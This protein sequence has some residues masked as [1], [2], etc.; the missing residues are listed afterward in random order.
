[1]KRHL[2]AWLGRSIGN[3]IILVS[4]ATA[5]GLVVLL[6]IISFTLFFYQAKKNDNDHTNNSINRIGD[7]YEFRLS[8][9]EHALSQLAKSSLIVNAFVDSSGREI[10]LTPIL[11]D[12]RL[13]IDLPVKLI[14]FDA[15]A[16]PFAGNMPDHLHLGE[17]LRHIAIES[18]KTE[19]AN[20]IPVMSQQRHN[21]ILAVPIFYPAAKSYEGVLLAIVETNALFD[22]PGNHLDADDCLTVS[23]MREPIYSVNCDANHIPDK[24]SRTIL[25]M[26]QVDSSSEINLV[27]AEKSRS[28]LFQLLLIFLLYL[29]MGIVAVA[30]AF[31]LSRKA[32]AVFVQQFK[33]ISDASVALAL[34]PNAQ[35]HVTWNHPDEIGQ[36]VDTFNIMVERLQHFQMSLETLIAQ[37]TDEIRIILD[38]VVDAIITFDRQGNI[39]SFNRAAETTFDY[40]ADEVIGRN[41]T[42]LLCQTDTTDEKTDSLKRN[43]LCLEGT[44]LATGRRKDDST[45]PVEIAVSSSMQHDQQLFIC[46]VRDITEQQRIEKMKSEFV[47]T[48]SH[49]LR[50]PLTSICGAL[51]LIVGGALGTM[52]EKANQLLGTAHKNSLRLR[53]LI[54][55]LLDMEK[56]VAGKMTL[57]LKEQSLMALVQSGLESIGAYGEQYKVSFKLVTHEDAMVNV[58]RDRLIQVL[59]NY[60]SNAAKFSP[61][62]SQV[63]VAIRKMHHV[64]RVE[65]TDKGPG[66]PS[67]FKERIFQKFSQA[68]SSDTRQKEGSG[69]GLAISKEWIE[70]MHGSVGFYSEKGQGSTFYFDLPLWQVEKTPEYPTA[71]TA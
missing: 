6:G 56:I 8:A 39:R 29:L 57:V 46:V 61:Q 44:E 23:T 4:V 22:L 33:S 59:N 2:S 42:I 54:N 58:D 14:L 18:L 51:G 68:D 60:L 64:V 52:P 43:I 67:E 19:Q 35:T 49:E 7:T 45:F 70:R 5:F 32:S 55:D 16:M 38:N 69:L 66:I 71:D 50:T 9:M 65:V 24:V 13:P 62:G 53:S 17:E 37:R 31:L 11:R 30:A 12:F 15:N 25:K 34:H 10:Y 41:L 27:Y 36:F 48:V 26:G 63:D 40:Q 28:F 20:I 3:R 1:M 21:I 47:S